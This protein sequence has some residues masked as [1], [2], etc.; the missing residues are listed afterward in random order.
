MGL[1]HHRMQSMPNAKLGQ[2]VRDLMELR[3][4]SGGDL[5]TAL[6]VSQTAISKILNG[7]NRPRQQA[8]VKLCEVLCTTDQERSLLVAAYTGLDGHSPG[9]GATNAHRM[10]Q[11][12]ADENDAT[13]DSLSQHVAG[14]R[15]EKALMEK[16]R[17]HE[18][19]CERAPILGDY[20]ADVVLQLGSQKI[21]L[22]YYAAGLQSFQLRRLGD[23]LRM[24][25]QSRLCD[26]AVAIMP[27][28]GE[29]QHMTLRGG[30]ELM[31]LDYFEKNYLN[32]AQ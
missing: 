17:A 10:E 23:L 27:N 19:T 12:N 13:M 28:E 8:F 29:I 2:M 26:K 3:S 32:P 16:L 7:R 22:E 31:T 15:L 30:A 4:I 21:A 20:R 5:A 9:S 6:G 11:R 14:V 24:L 1:I 25:E 18:V